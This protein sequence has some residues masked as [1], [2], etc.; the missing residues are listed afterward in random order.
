MLIFRI[1]IK[2]TMKSLVWKK[3]TDFFDYKS[4]FGILGK[5][6]DKLFLKKYMTELLT[7]R[8]HIVKEFAE[9]GKWKKMLPEKKYVW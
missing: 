1:D 6:A 3:T 4:P 9:S 2:I 5:I 7:E 8:N